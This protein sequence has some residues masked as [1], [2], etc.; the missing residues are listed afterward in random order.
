[1]A[2]FTQGSIRQGLFYAYSSDRGLHF[3]NPLPFG[4]PEDMPGYPDVLAKGDQV[5]LTWTEFNDSKLRLIVMKSTD[6][7][8]SWTPARQIAESTAGYDIPILLKGTGG[9]FVSWNSKSEGYHL[10]HLD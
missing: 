8:K 4:T 5:F 6:R 10:I 3:S 2:W 9:V 7:G 1:M